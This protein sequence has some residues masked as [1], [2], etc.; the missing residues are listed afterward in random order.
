MASFDLK[1]PAKNSLGGMIVLNGQV[2]A[3]SEQWN[4]DHIRHSIACL[5]S[6]H[7][8]L[9]LFGGDVQCSDNRHTTW[10]IMVNNYGWRDI[11]VEHLET[12]CDSDNP[13]P[14]P[15]STIDGVLYQGCYR[16]DGDRD[17]CCGPQEYGYTIESCRLA[18]AR[19]PFFA[20]QNNGWC[21]CAFDYGTP[22]T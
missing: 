20:L 7:H 19:F 5:D 11:S 21:S 6:G 8:V 13:I 14:S 18:C 1:L 17:F 9:E 2:L 12:L 15:P 10:Q 16:D 22:N 4:A 3:N